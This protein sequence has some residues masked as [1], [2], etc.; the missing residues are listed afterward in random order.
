ML[1]LTRNYSLKHYIFVFLTLQFTFVPFWE[2]YKIARALL[3]IFA[4]VLYVQNPGK[5]KVDNKIIYIF[6][7]YT[8]LASIQ[9]IF[10]GFSFLSVI[11]SFTLIFI[12]G[13]LIYKTYKFDFLIIFEKVFRIFTIISMVLWAAQNFIPGVKNILNEI[14]QL[15]FNYSSDVIPRSM[16]IYTYWNQLS[17]DTYVFSR[18]AGFLG[19][20]GSF[21]SLI[22]LAITINYIRGITLLNIRN[23]IYMIA[24][25]STIST[26]G[27]LAL[28]TIFLLFLRQKKQ[29]VLSLIIFP[30]LIAGA[31]YS[32]NT[33]SFMSS[34]I[35]EQATGQ[36][37]NSAKDVGTGRFAGAR[38]SIYVILKYPLYGRGLN[39]IS[40]ADADS[41]EFADYGWL[42][43]VSGFGL[44]FGGLF[45][46]YFLKGIYI[47][48]N[49]GGLGKYEFFVIASAIMI[50]LSSQPHIEKPFFL[51]FFFIGIY[52]IRNIYSKRMQ[53]IIKVR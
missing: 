25:I 7:I 12:F 18:N 4:F 22:I 28:A 35:Q 44:V 11:S 51:I 46:Y 47:F 15:A 5:I 17:I 50:N 31:I 48:S 32:Y 30:I 16:L 37:N 6:I 20:P 2:D 49:S 42:A 23:Y 26:A 36:L 43:Y 34:K 40:K 27:Y 45:T 41:L 24:M 1:N 10:W 3:V 21:A 19:E 9:G 13:F 14:I 33:F 8:I 29:R 38:K 53:K 52:H 39:S